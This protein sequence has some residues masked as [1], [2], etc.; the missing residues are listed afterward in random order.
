VRDLAMNTSYTLGEPPARIPAFATVT[1]LCPPLKPDSVGG[2][3]LLA[4][5]GLRQLTGRVDARLYF[6]EWHDS[7]LHVTYALRQRIDAVK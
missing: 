2:T 1:C 6:T 3:F 4:T 5:R 7:S